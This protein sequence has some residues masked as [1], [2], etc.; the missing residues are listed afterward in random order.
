MVRG[1]KCPFNQ[2]VNWLSQYNTYILI[3]I[4]L[5]KKKNIK[6]PN[7]LYSLSDTSFRQVI[8]VVNHMYGCQVYI[9]E[10]L[11]KLGNFELSILNRVF[12]SGY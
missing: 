5:F 4:N 2:I 11:E 3:S 12:T 6:C 9:G 1:G 7:N 8:Y 10:S